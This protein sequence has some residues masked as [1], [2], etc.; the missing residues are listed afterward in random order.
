MTDP[1]LAAWVQNGIL[2]LTLVVVALNLCAFIRYLG[3][4][5][6]LKRAALEQSEGLSKPVVTLLNVFEAPGG[7]EILGGELFVKVPNITLVNVGNGPALK[8]RWGLEVNGQEL[9]FGS[10]GY[11]ESRQTLNTT[12]SAHA[13]PRFGVRCKY[14][15]LGGARYESITDIDQSRVTDFKSRRE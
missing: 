12:L 9:V 1:T 11:L 10:L 4:T 8:V 13:Y 14:E 6:V 15:S 5:D 2:F 3:A 7:A